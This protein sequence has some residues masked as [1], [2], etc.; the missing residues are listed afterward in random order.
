M[1]GSPDMLLPGLGLLED[2]L[3]RERC[4]PQR[5][6]ALPTAA[7]RRRGHGCRP[8][9]G[10]GDALPTPRRGRRQQPPPCCSMHAQLRSANC[11]RT[12]S[13][14]V[15][16][17][18]P[19]APQMCPRRGAK[20]TVS[21]GFHENKERAQRRAPQNCTGVEELC[22]ARPRPG[23]T[24]APGRQA[25]GTNPWDSHGPAQAALH[26][27]VLRTHRYSSVGKRRPVH[28]S[29]RISTAPTQSYN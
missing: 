5:E 2:R 25:Q 4:V 19:P 16:L 9:Q 1:R 29:E 20:A 22:G 6:R 13:L 8:G 28:T 27:P 15:P 10:P 26:S 11:I 21:E 24:V 3:S 7:A 17:S 23:V 14:L 12:D 18:P